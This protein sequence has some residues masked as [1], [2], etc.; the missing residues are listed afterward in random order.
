NGTLIDES[1]INILK[2]LRRVDLRISFHS[3]DR[4]TFEKFAGSKDSYNKVI[5]SIQMLSDEDVPFSVLTVL[6]SINESTIYNTINY[7]SSNSIR[8]AISPYIFPNIFS[9]GNNIDFRP[10]KEIIDKLTKDG[11]IS[12]KCSLCGA[13]KTKFWISCNGDIFP[14]EMYRDIKISNIFDEDLREIWHSSIMDK[15][16][17]KLT[18]KE[19]DC[20][21]CVHNPYCNYCPALCKTFH[22]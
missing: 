13:L 6:T 19:L 22:R 11:Y 3:I 9:S 14:C 15:L 16:R 1:F 20:N 21:I 8:Y 10:S 2:K 5:K 18:L 17:N 4:S 7:L 12:K